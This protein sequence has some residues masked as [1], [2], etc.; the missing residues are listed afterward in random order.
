MRPL[1]SAFLL[2]LASSLMLVAGGGSSEALAAS[3]KKQILRCDRNPYV[4]PSFR[5]CVNGQNGVVYYRL[6]TVD[7]THVDLVVS[8]EGVDMQQSGPDAVHVLL[9]N[10]SAHAS[11][12]SPTSGIVRHMYQDAVLTIDEVWNGAYP[13]TW[14]IRPQALQITMPSQKMCDSTDCSVHK[15]REKSPL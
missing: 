3:P 13:P 2:C 6:D 8:N 15:L 10:T 1:R 11:G 9:A 4:S 14:V 5:I 7:G 12:I